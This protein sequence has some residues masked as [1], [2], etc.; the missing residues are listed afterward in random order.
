MKIVIPTKDNQVDSHF[1]HCEH[2]SIAEISADN[3]ISSIELMPS[4]EGC[5]C[6]SNIANQLADMGVTVMLAG[7]MG[8]GAVN[9]I[10]QA[11]IQVFRGCSGDVRE[12]VEAF[13]AE[14]V[15]D[16]GMTCAG[17]GESGDHVCEH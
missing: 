16:S 7:N 4:P 13:L 14:K 1:G 15:K 12:L 5:G 6:K 10:S 8:Q 3:K 11:G 2:F 17:H 9:K